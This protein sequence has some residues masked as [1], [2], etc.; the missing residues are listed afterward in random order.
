MTDKYRVSF[1]YHR[2]F[3]T[4]VRWFNFEVWGSL[5]DFKAKGGEFEYITIS[6]SFYP[7]Y[8]RES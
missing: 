2:F 6:T 8:L 4:L 3:I 7:T 5:V 1:I